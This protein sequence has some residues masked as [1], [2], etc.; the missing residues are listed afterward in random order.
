MH[1]VCIIY[2]SISVS[3]HC[4]LVFFY[5]YG[6]YIYMYLTL[7][8]NISI[9]CIFTDRFDACISTYLVVNKKFLK[10]LLPL[11]SY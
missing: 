6:A 1:A 7:V 9:S 5:T 11:N 8:T 2:C 3:F 4:N 10:T